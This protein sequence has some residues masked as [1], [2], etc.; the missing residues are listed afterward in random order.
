LTSDGKVSAL[1]EFTL[2]VMFPVQNSGS[3]G[4][5]RRLGDFTLKDDRLVFVLEE[6]FSGDGE[7]GSRSFG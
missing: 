1:K 4:S 7:W 3:R 6:P 2:P 5:K